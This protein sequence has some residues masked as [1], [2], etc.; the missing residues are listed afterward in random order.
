[1]AD[2]ILSFGILSTFALDMIP[3][4]FEFDVGSGP[5]SENIKIFHIASTMPVK[6]TA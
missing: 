3:S 5:C 1:M 6:S 2:S 4:S